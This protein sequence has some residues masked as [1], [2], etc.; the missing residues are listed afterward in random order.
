MIKKREK[1]D[2]ATLIDILD[3]KFAKNLKFYV[4]GA[5]IYCE[6]N[7]TTEKVIVGKL[8]SEYYDKDWLE[9]RKQIFINLIDTSTN[10]LYI[11]LV[12][13][14]K[15]IANFRE[16]NNIP[17]GDKVIVCVPANYIHKDLYKDLINK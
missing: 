3:I 8:E 1:K 14:L 16:T 9:I 12:K 6:N 15:E 13:L 5:Y 11:E 7:I 17:D 4:D 2:D 10:F